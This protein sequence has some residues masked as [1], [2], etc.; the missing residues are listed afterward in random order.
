LN[1]TVDRSEC[2][3][4]LAGVRGYP[5]GEH[6]SVGF[7]HQ[8]LFSELIHTPLIVQ[9]GMMPIGTRDASLVQLNSIWATVLRWL[10][11][12]DDVD[13]K[14]AAEI[15]SRK[16]CVDLAAT[17]DDDRCDRESTRELPSI[18]FV[19]SDEATSLQVPRWSAIWQPNCGSDS[20]SEPESIRLYLS[21]DDR[22]QQNDAT[23]RAM[24]IAEAMQAA[25]DAYIQW[26]REGSPSESRP[27]LPECLSHRI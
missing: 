21:P 24:E 2:L 16:V 15:A 9:P 5:L 6:R 26:L 25:R 8:D 7:I 14:V 3:V 19:A 20:L 27:L 4:V 22:W 18:C 11:R 17:P 23:S 10:A 13:S 1:E 12:D